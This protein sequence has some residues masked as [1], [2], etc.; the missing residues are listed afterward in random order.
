MPDPRRLPRR[1]PPEQPNCPNLFPMPN[2]LPIQPRL[3]LLHLP[4]TI[5]SL[6][7]TL[8][9]HQ[10][11]RHWLSW[12]RDQ[13]ERVFDLQCHWRMS[14]QFRR[15]CFLCRIWTSVRGSV[16][17]M[18]IVLGIRM[19]WMW[20]IVFWLGIVRWWVRRRIRFLGRRNV[21]RTMVEPI[22]VI[23]YNILMYK[24]LQI[25]LLSC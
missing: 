4:S 9:L 6:Q 20:I 16:L 21:I 19:I 5:Q 25:W 23:W 18:M 3:Q 10:H 2:R 7:L 8:Q 14:R 22:Q 24:F 12:M 11:R 17:I 13:S 15:W 1:L